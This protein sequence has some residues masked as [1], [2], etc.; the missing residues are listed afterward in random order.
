MDAPVG[1]G[2]IGCAG[3]AEKVCVAI[4]EAT[5]AT[6]VAVGSRTKEKAEQFVKDNAPGAKAY[7]SYDAVLDDSDV[8]VVYIPL[9]TTMKKEW[10]LKAAAKGKHVLCD[11]PISINTEE[12]K[13]M[14]EACAKAGVQFMDNTMMMHHPRLSDGTLRNSLKDEEFGTVK[15]VVSCFTIP[16]GN[17]DGWANSNIRMNAT[18]EPYGCLGDLGWYNIRV[19]QWAFQY[20]E[21]EEVSC[22]YFDQTKDG[23]PT[24]AHAIM[25]YSGGRTATFDCSFKCAL[26]QW[27]EVVGTN[28]RAYWDDF[29]INHLESSAGYTVDSSGI[30]AKAI[31]FPKTVHLNQNFEG[32]TQQHTQLVQRM[33]QLAKIGT[34]DS[35]WP[36]ISEQT[37]R[38][39]M[40]LH[41]SAQNAGVWTKI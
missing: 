31:T 41:S 35:H 16:F 4:A 34:P 2:V 28:R 40:A 30:A 13:A 18:T 9:P 5:D 37:Q 12:A 27:V 22:H 1:W 32:Y 33:S 21:P 7:D 24:T 8:K 14:V 36:T 6:V 15:H 19:S 10:V 38:I 23:V 20:E 39:M 29:V 26:R 17:D 11:K 25:K 3:I